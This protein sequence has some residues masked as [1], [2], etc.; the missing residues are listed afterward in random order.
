[1]T[2]SRASYVICQDAFCQ[3]TPEKLAVYPGKFFRCTLDASHMAWVPF[4]C[5]V[6]ERAPHSDCTALKVPVIVK[7]CA[8]SIKEIEGL[9]VLA[10]CS[11]SAVDCSGLTQYLTEVKFFNK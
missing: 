6:F 2:S 4:G 8:E 3:V 9:K 5:L 10:S 1:M 7:E 11:A